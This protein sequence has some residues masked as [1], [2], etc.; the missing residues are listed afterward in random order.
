M[1]ILSKQEVLARIGSGAGFGSLTVRNG[2]SRTGHIWCEHVN[3]A[4]CGVEK[5]VAPHYDTDCDNN[6]EEFPVWIKTNWNLGICRAC[7]RAL[8]KP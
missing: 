3:G 2:H 1:K 4:L 8:L 7:L 6:D 5:R